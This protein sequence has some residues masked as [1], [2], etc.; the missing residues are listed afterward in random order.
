MD[1]IPET[2]ALKL[3]DFEW[4]YDRRPLRDSVCDRIIRPTQREEVVSRQKPRFRITE[5]ID[6]DRRRLVENREWVDRV[7]Q[8]TPEVIEWRNTRATYPKK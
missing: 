7:D 1:M 6:Y 3:K 5:R 2:Q 8:L 4:F